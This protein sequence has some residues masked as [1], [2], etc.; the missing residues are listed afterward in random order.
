M[1]DML[2]ISVLLSNQPEEGLMDSVSCEQKF[3]YCLGKIRSHNVDDSSPGLVKVPA[4]CFG[5]SGPGLEKVLSQHCDGSGTCLIKV[6][7]QC[8]SILWDG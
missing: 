6:P 1:S 2:L 7:R 3:W 8:C 5:G 4:L